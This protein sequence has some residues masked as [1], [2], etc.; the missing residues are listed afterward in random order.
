MKKSTFFIFAMLLSATGILAEGVGNM[1]VIFKNNGVDAIYNVGSEHWGTGDNPNVLCTDL[2]GLTEINE[3]NFGSVVSLFLDGAI[4]VSWGDVPA[5]QQYLQY[6][7]YKDGTAASSATIYYLY[8]SEPENWVEG[9]NACCVNNRRYE[10]HNANVDVAAV[11]YAIGGYGVYHIDVEMKSR[12]DGGDYWTG[13]KTATFTVE[14]PA[15]F[16]IDENFVQNIGLTGISYNFECQNSGATSYLWKINDE[17]VTDNTFYTLDYTFATAGTYEVKLIVNGDNTITK[18]VRIFEKSAVQNK[19]VGGDMQDEE[20]WIYAKIIPNGNFIQEP[21][22]SWTNEGLHIER[23]NGTTWDRFAVFQPVY[24]LKDNTYTFGCDVLTSSANLGCL[25]EIF[26]EKTNIPQDNVNFADNN[27]FEDNF[28]AKISTW[29]NPNSFPASY[30]GK[31]SDVPNTAGNRTKSITESGMYFVIVRF[32]SW[33]GT[34]DIKLNNIELTSPQD[35]P[36]EI[37]TTPIISSRI[38]SAKSS[39]TVISN[40]DTEVLLYSVSGVLLQNVSAKNLSP[41]TFNNLQAG[42]Y[43]VKIGGEIFKTA[44]Y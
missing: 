40:A 7:L 15:Q 41:T 11:A 10:I 25:V 8:F 33:E 4:S 14:N 39:I 18:T 34:F 9:V 13:F 22:V 28:I 26:I 12:K 27:G 35:V 30:N 19:I 24:L 44:V 5:S 3:K 20:K 2:E 38:F 32:V 29:D 6:R 17:N 23:N 31:W 37:S 36:T 21:V 42:I 1:A 16:E 43:F